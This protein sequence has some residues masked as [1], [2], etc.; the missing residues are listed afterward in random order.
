MKELSE[1]AGTIHALLERLNSERLP[2]ALELKA[3]VDRGAR[4]ADHDILFLK[5]V[6]DDAENARSLAAK[7]PEF[8][9]LVARLIGLYSEI[10]RMGLENEQKAED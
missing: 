3:K 9:E 2:R 8:R 6:F 1:E 5:Q 7:H 10:T 4:L